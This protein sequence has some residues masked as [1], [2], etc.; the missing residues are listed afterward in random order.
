MCSLLNTL[1]EGV[2]DPY[3]TVLK[4]ATNT[5]LTTRI[6]N[7]I[8]FV[9][10]IETTKGTNR[11]S[12]T[13]VTTSIRIRGWRFFQ[14]TKFVTTHIFQCVFQTGGI[15]RVVVA[16]I[17]VLIVVVLVVLVQLQLLSLFLLSPR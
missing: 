1:V 9:T 5:T 12:W 17:L 4:T 3:C 16:V 15:Q 10:I 6:A 14:E 8:I 2:D 13:V 7:A 11:L